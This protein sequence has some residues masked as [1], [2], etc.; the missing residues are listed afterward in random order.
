[1]EKL[2]DSHYISIDPVHLPQQQ[3]ESQILRSFE[4][5]YAILRTQSKTKG[6]RSMS[7]ACTQR[8]QELRQKL[9]GVAPAV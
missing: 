1:M 9:Q 2:R 6:V 3:Y 4:Q 8:I 7:N 5:N